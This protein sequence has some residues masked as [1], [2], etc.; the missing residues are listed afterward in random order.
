LGKGVIAS[1]VHSSVTDGLG[2]IGVLI[3]LESA[4]KD[5]RM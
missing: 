2:R 5:I 1:Y 4:G 3:A